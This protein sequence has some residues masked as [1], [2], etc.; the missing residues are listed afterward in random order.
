MIL[1][2]LGC[3]L[4]GGEPADRDSGGEVPGDSGADTAPDPGPD[5]CAGVPVVSW[6]NFGEGFLVENCQACHASGTPN[7]Y[8]APED[9]A[10]DT[11]ADVRVHRDRILARAT[12][13]A[14]TMPPMGGVSDDDRYLLEVWL[15]CWLDYWD[16][17]ATARAR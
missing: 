8:G 7:R 10:F 15:V 1:L 12:G 4:L 17:T 14:P 16:D 3:A 5:P 11:E 2:L 13:E 9:V 6:T